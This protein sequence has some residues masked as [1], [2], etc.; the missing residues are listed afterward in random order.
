MYNKTGR[1][2]A[3]SAGAWHL[4]IVAGSVT[5]TQDQTCEMQPPEDVG[6]YGGID[7]IGD[8]GNVG[9]YGSDVGGYGGGYG[10]NR[11]GG[12][13]KNGGGSGGRKQGGGGGGGVWKRQH[14][15]GGFG[16]GG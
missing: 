4:L 1:A 6:G 10:G 11:N 5:K 9:G 15:W 7:T 13:K 16:E 14:K 3:I 8:V 2:N 12:G